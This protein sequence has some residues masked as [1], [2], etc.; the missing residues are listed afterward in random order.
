M[1]FLYSLMACMIERDF[2]LSLASLASNWSSPKLA[3]AWLS[4]RNAS[5]LTRITPSFSRET[6]MLDERLG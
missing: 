3:F 2:S 1:A 5:S 4:R 6:V